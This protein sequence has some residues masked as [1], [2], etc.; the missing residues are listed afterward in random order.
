MKFFH[1]PWTR[2]TDPKNQQALPLHDNVQ[3]SEGTDF[4]EFVLKLK[5]MS[6]RSLRLR[7]GLARFL[8]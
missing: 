4:F 8:K 6:G 2:L 3:N 5:S 1:D 7:P